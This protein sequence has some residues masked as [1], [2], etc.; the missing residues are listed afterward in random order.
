MK[1][2]DITTYLHYGQPTYKLQLYEFDGTLKPSM[3]LKYKPAEMYPTMPLHMN[4][5]LFPSCCLPQVIG[6]A[7]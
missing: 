4:V 1:G 2:F 3:Y 7:S 6:V 5:R